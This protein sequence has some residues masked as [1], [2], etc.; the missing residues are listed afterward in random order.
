M[1]H[2]PFQPPPLLGGPMTQSF[3]G[4]LRFRTWGPNP[5]RAASRERVLDCGGGVRLQ[6]FA[7]DHPDGGSRGLVVLLHGWEGD[8]EAT[9][10]LTAGR[11]LFERGYDVFRLNYRD[12]G[13]SHRLNEGLFWA[14]ALDEVFE[15]VRSVAAEKDGRPVFLLGFS[16]GGSFSLRIAKRHAREP[17][18]G[19][20]A[21]A[22]VSPLLDP[23]RATEAIDGS[24][25]LRTHFTRK[26]RK[27]LRKKQRAFPDRYDFRDAFAERT[28]RSM[29]DAVAA[30]YGPHAS[31]R[32]YFASYALGGRDLLDLPVP[33]EMYT[34]E[35]DPV[36]PI[37]DFHRL[38]LGASTHL[39]ILPRGG[40]NA[41]L[42]GWALR[43]WYE[44][45]IASF[46]AGQ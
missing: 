11:H 45:P 37:D 24:L 17:I 25:L 16:M 5:M 40:H 2:S 28:L 23:D 21:V 3:V 6:G 35:D 27:S 38:E 30:R 33:V 42:H 34:S 4:S 29:T 46:F 7:S 10:I 22:V 18:P 31:A 15:A 39:T 43:A 36:I 19:L 20:K 14:S 1:N 26:W 9:Y 12:H 44:P 41:F 32:D 13:D 8:A